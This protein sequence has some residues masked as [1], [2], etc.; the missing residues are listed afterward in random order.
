MYQHELATESTKWT[1]D[2]ISST[3]ANT[4]YSKAHTEN[5]LNGLSKV[6][7]FDTFPGQKRGLSQA[8]KWW[9]NG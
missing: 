6:R 4:F 9:I 1:D 2:T 7:G 8:C 5:W 3:T